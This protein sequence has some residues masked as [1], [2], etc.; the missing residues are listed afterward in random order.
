MLTFFLS[1]LI[2]GV[3]FCAPPG[4]VNA[5]SLRRGLGRGFWPAFLVQTGSL[6]GDMAWATIALIGATVLVRTGPARL[7]L[8]TLGSA[9]LLW[10]A[11]GALRD[12][13]RGTL[14]GIAAPGTRGDFATGA[15]LSLSNPFAVAF[16]LGA[17]GGIVADSASSPG[18]AQF[19]A[20]L[21]GFFL[22][23]LAWCLA[24]S[25]LAAWGRRFVWAGF[26][27][28]LN[29]A[30]GLVLGYFGLRLLLGTVGVT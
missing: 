16:W 20:F 23:A 2:L 9:L 4:A 13:H 8:E 25:L 27:R 7:G 12:A 1:A 18:P 15:L 3:A 6:I 19:A 14:P 22:G 26:F 10:L 11:V 30:C 17:G 24:I 21:G 5:E 29:L 28:W